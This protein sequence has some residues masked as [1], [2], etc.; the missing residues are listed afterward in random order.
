MDSWASVARSVSAP[1]SFTPNLCIG[2]SQIDGLDVLGT[3]DLT[4]R[5]ERTCVSRR[6]SVSLGRLGQHMGAGGLDL[7]PESYRAVS[8]RKRGLIEL[9]QPCGELIRGRNE[10]RPGLAS[11]GLEEGREDLAPA[12]V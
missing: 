8:G 5:A 4:F 7:T 11:A 10:R 2:G 12:G 3:A 1:V 9:Y 6:D